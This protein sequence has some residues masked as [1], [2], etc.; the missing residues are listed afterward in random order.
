M[1]HLKFILAKPMILAYD[2]NIDPFIPELWANESLAILEENM[3]AASLIHRDFEPELAKYGDIVHTRRPGEFVAKRKVPADDVTVQDAT[4]TDVQ[5]PLD[6]HIHV[7]FLI[8]DGEESKSFK[9]LVETY[10][11]PAM[12]AQCRIIDRVV[13]GQYPHF[14]K[15]AYGGLGTLTTSNARDRILGTRN[16]LNQN[17]AY[18]DN[19]QM[20]LS[21]STETTFLN[22]DIFTQAYQ[23]GDDGTALQEAWLGR[24]YGFNMYMC[25]NM[26]GVVSTGLT[27]V[28]GAVNHSGGYAA[29]AVTMTVNGLSSALSAGQWF[30][31][32]GDDT[33]QQVVSTVGGATPT[34]ITM[35][36][37]LR[38]AVANTAVITIYSV[39]TTGGTTYAAGWSK[40]IIYNGS[41]TTVPEVGQLVSFTT[42]VG[43]DATDFVYT[44]VEVDTT[45][46]TILLDRP[47]GKTVTS[48]DAINF[49]PAG[50]YNLAFHR[51]CMSLVVRPLAMPRAGTGALS[52]VVNH[53][54]LSMRATITYNGTKQGHLVT[55]D[56]LCGIAILDTNLGAVLLG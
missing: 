31:V 54:D 17:K 11:A 42:D 6:Q 7:S 49:G 47:L 24:K 27:T 8:K 38:S 53:N 9:D 26:A 52:A 29:G 43:D 1:S 33:P 2:N 3:V 44:I 55:L 39:N 5:V 23:V 45:A 10:M 28:T 20:V 32:A 16:K 51:N 40:D 18:M 21:P 22:L 15:N 25:Q 37:G 46:H 50:Q 4:A 36:P 48:G 35:S 13:L 19:R 41:G 12:L 14:L 34:S 30:T 56:M